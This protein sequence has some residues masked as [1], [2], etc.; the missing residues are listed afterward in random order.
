MSNKKKIVRKKPDPRVRTFF[1]LAFPTVMIIALAM[2]VPEETWWAW[3]LL[4]VWQFIML[5]NFVDSYHEVL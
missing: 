3:I 2:I 5:K 4:A 1:I